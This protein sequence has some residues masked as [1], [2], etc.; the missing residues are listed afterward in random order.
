MNVLRPRSA[1]TLVRPPDNADRLRGIAEAALRRV[2][3][4]GVLP[5]PLNRLLEA[6]RLG[7]VADLEEDRESFLSKMSAKVQGVARS[8]LQKLRGVLDVRE[9]KVWV[10]ET[11]G[12]PRRSRFPT[13]HEIAHDLCPWHR[14]DQA[15]LDTDETLSRRVRA[16]L[17]REANYLGAQ[18]LFQGSRFGERVRDAKESLASALALAEAHETTFHS[19]LWA[20]VEEQDRPVAVAVYRKNAVLDRD[21]RPTYR[22]REVY[23]SKRFAKSFEAVELPETLSAADPWVD[24]L[25]GLGAVATGTCRLKCGGAENG[26]TWETWTNTF[27]LFVLVRREP[28][29]AAATGL[30][31]RVTGVFT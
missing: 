28:K 10:Q 25:S 6:Q 3:A 17:E 1:P 5:T 14:I 29:G 22:Q 30:I 16:T 15:F 13:A 4:Y 7:L 24:G 27:S 19:T 2:D 12:K 9:R 21:G 20:W 31:R 26:F 8:M 18:L 23:A 11:P